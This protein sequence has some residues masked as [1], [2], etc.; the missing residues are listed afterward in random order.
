MPSPTTAPV[1]RLGTS[2][3]DRPDLYFC[4]LQGP[5]RLF[6][7]RKNWRFEEVDAGPASCGED[8]STGAVLADVDGDG[9]LDLLVNGITAGTRL[10][11]NDGHGGW[12]ESTRSGLSRTAWAMSM[13]LA[14]IDGDGDLDLYCTH[15]IDVMHL[16]DPTTR[17]ALARR[18]DQ[19]EVSKVNGESTRSPKWK[20]RFEATA[21]RKV[22]ELP[23]GLYR[24]DGG[25]VFTA[26]QEVPGTYVDGQGKP[27]APYRDWGLSVM[28]RDLNGDGAPDLYV[29]NDN[30]SPD[31]IW[32]NTGKGTFRPLEPG[33]LRHTSRSS[34]GL[35]FADIDRD[36]RDDFLVVDMLA[37]DHAKRMTQL[38]REHPDRSQRERSAEV[39]RFGRNTLFRARADG[40]FAETACTRDWRPPVGPGA[41]SSWTSISTA[42]RICWSRPD[43]PST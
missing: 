15:Y 33:V 5:N 28:F 12:A 4:N 25:G 38:V 39:P 10:F 21:D 22:R 26:I 11:L 18:S 37:P 40:T 8:L 42:T 1:W 2:T 41:R 9:D 23:Y 13:A 19:W 7:N 36:G 3:T 30:A 14:D 24:N 27:L 34:M 6:L 32:I 20:D 29:C 35:D 16:A 31:R 43:S 17:F